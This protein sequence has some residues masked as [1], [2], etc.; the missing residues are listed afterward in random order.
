MEGYISAEL[1]T[2]FITKTKN[3]ETH[4]EK[5]FTYLKDSKKM[6]YYSFNNIYGNNINQNA[7]II[8]YYI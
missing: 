7:L 6:I 2:I 3:D 4:Y 8:M 1:F 5:T